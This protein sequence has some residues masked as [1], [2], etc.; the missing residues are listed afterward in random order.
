MNLNIIAIDDQDIN[1]FLIEEIANK[2]DIKIKTFLNPIESLEYIKNNEVDIIFTDYA[3]PDMN[4]ITLIKKVKEM[5]VDII[6]VMIT[7]VSDDISLKISALEHGAS[8]FLTKPINI[9]EFQAKIKNLSELKVSQ[10]ILKNFNMT[11]KNEI[12]VATKNLI[13]REHEM[14]QILSATAEYRD[15]ET[16]F[17]T[18]RVAHYSKIL[19]KFYGLSIKDQEIIFYASPLHDIG[20][21]GIADNILLKPG[22]LTDIEYDIMKT[23]SMIGYDI[24]CNSK[25]N[26][27]QAGAIIA[28]SHHEKY[29]GT[30]YP[31]GLK[32]EYIPV[33][34]RI[35]AIADVFDALTSIRPYKKAWTFEEGIQFL[36]DNSGSHFDPQL[37]DIFIE[38]KE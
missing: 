13:D 26:F 25:N 1:L 29:D 38:N 8:D 7:A 18:M 10:K 24:L 27:L 22:K 36:K 5:N 28:K 3:M 19:A 23:H 37:I 4:G 30:G 32:G 21:V 17:H 35:S 14:L 33:F 20:K 15:P 34:G 6:C 2:I 11:L 12:D 16:G 31:F 9:A